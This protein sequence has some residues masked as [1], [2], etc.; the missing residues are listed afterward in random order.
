MSPLFDVWVN[1]PTKGMTGGWSLMAS[2]ITLEQAQVW[3]TTCLFGV[4]FMVHQLKKDA[5]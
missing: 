1:T 4:R 3:K 2:G 5:E